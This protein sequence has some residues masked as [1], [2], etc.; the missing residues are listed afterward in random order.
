M[1]DADNRTYLG[2]PTDHIEISILDILVT[3]S[4]N[5]KLLIVGSLMTGLC[6]FGISYILPQTFESTA[7]LQAP[8]PARSQQSI[9]HVIA[10]QLTT[11]VV[12]TPVIVKLELSRGEST[13]ETLRALREQIKVAVGGKDKLITLTVAASTPQKAQAISF[14]ILEQAYLQSRPAGSLRVRIE[15]ELTGAKNRLKAAENTAV[16]LLKRIETPNSSIGGTDVVSGYAGLLNAA[17]D[18]QNKIGELKAQ[19]EGMS[20]S[21]LIQAPTLPEKASRPK[22]ALLAIGFTLAAGLLILFFIFV[23][24]A[25]RKLDTDSAD[26]AKLARIQKALYLTT[27]IK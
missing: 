1:E 25:L 14:A 22:K 24:Q 2:A 16:S 13:E 9:E 27:F 18:A 3:L 4:E 6:A 23:R 8:A 19:L 12:L 11:S 21:Q 7:V 10:S 20:E 5:A 17:A 15:E 26:A